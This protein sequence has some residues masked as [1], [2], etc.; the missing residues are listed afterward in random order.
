MVRGYKLRKFK[1]R[2]RTYGKGR[3]AKYLAKRRFKKKSK[4]RYL[5]V[6]GFPA[7]KMVKLRYVQNITL[8]PAAG[9][10]A[11]HRFRANSIYDP[12]ATGTGHQPSNHDKF[13]LIYDRYTVVASKCTVKFINTGTTNQT[14]GTLLLHLSEDGTDL[15]TAHASGG[16]NNV[17]EQPRLAYNRHEI[18]VLTTMLNPVFIRK[19][20]SAKKF[21]GVTNIV[22]KATYGADMG[23]NPTEGA[24]YEVALMSP[25]D[26]NNPAALKFRV[27]IDYIAV[28]TEPKL[29]DAS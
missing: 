4:R 8:D 3:R 10:I 1:R 29:A 28:L 19:T 11:S 5:P 6:G 13:E 2:K 27:I 23:A 16:A 25:D 7:K 17:L 22:G 21:H 14:P 24:F 20:Y 26:S 12:D 18:G 15:T 9:N